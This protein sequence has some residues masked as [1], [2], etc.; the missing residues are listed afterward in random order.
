METDDDLYGFNNTPS[1]FYYPQPNY[2]YPT[3]SSSSLSSSQDPLLSVTAASV[4]MYSYEAP[5]FDYVPYPITYPTTQHKKRSIYMSGDHAGSSSSLTLDEEAARHGVVTASLVSQLDLDLGQITPATASTEGFDLVLR[6][7]M[8]HKLQHER[9]ERNRRS[10]K[11][12]RERKKNLV[13]DYETESL[14]VAEALKKL[15]EFKWG[16]LG[17]STVVYLENILGE[18]KQYLELPVE[19]KKTYALKC[20]NQCHQHA[21]KLLKQNRCTWFLLLQLSPPEESMPSV[22]TTATHPLTPIIPIDAYGFDLFDMMTE[23]ATKLAVSP[24]QITALRDPLWLTQL[25]SQHYQLCLLTKCL[26]ALRFHGHCLEFPLIDAACRHFLDTILTTDQTSRFAAWSERHRE[27]I[28][29]LS[30]VEDPV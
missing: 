20:L 21:L 17:N 14:E 4:N 18:T 13:I 11:G 28:H 8:T 3:E 30:I 9:L 29:G 16:Q 15:K 12:R 24:A 1:S 27:E 6:P 23:C 2:L 19:E 22:R 10:A 7:T 26:A 25:S 5:S